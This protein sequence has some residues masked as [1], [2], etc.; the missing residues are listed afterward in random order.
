M[1][2]LLKSRTIKLALIQAL[3]GILIA[4][5]TELDLIGYVAI[6]KSVADIMLR[7]VT[8]QAVEDK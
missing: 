1:K 7:M 2:Q 6:A 3:A 5:F 4:V 8:T